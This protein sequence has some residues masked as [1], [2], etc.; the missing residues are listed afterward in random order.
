MLKPKGNMKSSKI[1]PMKELKRRKSLADTLSEDLESQRVVFFKPTEFEN[2]NLNIDTEYL[3]MP[4]DITETPSRE[5]GNYLNAFTQQRMYLRTVIGWQVC[6][7]EEARRD[8]NDASS[9]EYQ[10]LTRENPKMSETAKDKMVQ[11]D[12]EVKKYFLKYQDNLNKLQ[13]L[14]SNLASIDDAIFSISREI[15]RKIGDNDTESREYNVSKR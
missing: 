15:T 10:R 12:P 11:S 4:R 7:V 1:N 14:E 2:G 5:L 3:I 9:P 8:Y 13:L 6:Y